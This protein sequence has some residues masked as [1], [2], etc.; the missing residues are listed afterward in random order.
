MTDLFFI[1]EKNPVISSSCHDGQERVFIVKTMLCYSQYATYGF[2][3]WF[4]DQQS[5]HAPSRPQTVTSE[6]TSSRSPVTSTLPSTNVPTYN[7]TLHIE[8]VGTKTGTV[9]KICLLNDEI[10]RSCDFFFSIHAFVLIRCPAVAIDRF[11]M[12]HR[13]SPFISWLFLWC[14]GLLS[15]CALPNT[16][17]KYEG[18]VIFR[19][20]SCHGRD[21]AFRKGEGK[22]T[23][24]TEKRWTKESKKFQKDV[25]KWKR[26]YFQQWIQTWVD[27][28]KTNFQWR[29]WK[30]TFR[31]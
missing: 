12:P 13:T 3:L 22:R 30:T 14:S 23:S 31:S 5:T 28:N 1:K 6:T 19:R 26:W 18:V 25:Y 24:T 20:R 27:W 8:A 2:L 11:T 4:T 17:E 21:V 16:T 7:S 9:H 29:R 10:I 15:L